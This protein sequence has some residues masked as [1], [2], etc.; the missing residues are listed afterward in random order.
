MN[1]NEF[2]KTYI[3]SDP[4]GGL[5]LKGSFFGQS[6]LSPDVLSVN[7]P[8]GGRAIKI[9]LIDAPSGEKPSP[10]AATTGV[11]NDTPTYNNGA[12]GVGATLTGT[13][14][15]TALGA[16]DGITLALNDLLLVKNQ[17]DNT[18]N[19]LY[20]LTRLA[21]VGVTYQLTRH[22][23]MDVSS[24]FNG[25]YMLVQTGTV[26]AGRIYNVTYVSNFVV[27]TSAVV[28]VWTNQSA[29]TSGLLKLGA[30]MD[31]TLRPVLDYAN[32]SSP[33]SLSTNAVGVLIS[34][35]ATPNR[36]TFNIGGGA[37]DGVTA[38]FF[39]G[40]VNGTQ[41]A[42]NTTAGFTG[43]FVNFQVAGAKQFSIDFAG[44]GY[45][46]GSLNVNGGLSIIDYIISGGAYSISFGGLRTYSSGNG[47]E[48]GRFQGSSNGTFTGASGLQNGTA[49]FNTVNQSGTAG[50]T[51]LFVNRTETTVG[52]GAQ[53]LFD[54][55]KNSVSAF[56]VSSTKV[57][58]ASGLTFQL[59]NSAV[60]GLIAGSL[61]ALTNATIIILDSTGQAYRIPC[62]I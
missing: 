40:S 37:F 31:A 19:G 38:G 11:L 9:H 12:S 24:E 61:A 35:I 18:Q 2:F 36:G 58:V 39:V 7:D 54:L 55:Q 42:I 59:G 48:L 30:P 50:F 56:N 3:T 32:T 46:N 44:R 15:N 28:F 1:T 52:S 16:Q 41:F 4:T 6:G 34:A 14:T 29:I 20:Q 49:I 22:V 25:A 51:D 8:T 33:L 60:T 57:K 47:V 26:N 43:D 17:A 21:A 62:I 10:L 53:L 23:S 27:G 13:T 45:F 5:A